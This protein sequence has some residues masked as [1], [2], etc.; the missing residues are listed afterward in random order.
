[1]FTG[2]RSGFP[3]DQLHLLLPFLLSALLVVLPPLLLVTWFSSWKMLGI[4]ST[5]SPRP[6]ASWL[7]RKSTRSTGPSKG[8]LNQLWVSTSLNPWRCGGCWLAD[9]YL[10]LSWAWDPS[11]FARH[12]RLKY[13][14]FAHHHWCGPMVLLND[15]FL[16]GGRLQ[17]AFE[18]SKVEAQTHSD[19]NS[20]LLTDMAAAR[21]AADV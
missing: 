1:M 8:S 10:S 2:L 21:Q 7:Y 14:W 20:Q 13:S 9:Y 6:M 16:F 19:L 11:S 12:P 5:K 3:L 18:E 15:Q 17:L 4:E